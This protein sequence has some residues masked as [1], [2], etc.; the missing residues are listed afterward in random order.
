[1]ITFCFIH[2]KKKSKKRKKKNALVH[3]FRRMRRA[4]HGLEGLSSPQDCILK[5][6]VI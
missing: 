2:S 3:I 1:M 5:W 6:S 4:S